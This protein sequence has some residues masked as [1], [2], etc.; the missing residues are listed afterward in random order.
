MPAHPD[1]YAYPKTILHHPVDATELSSL[2]ASKRLEETLFHSVRE[3]DLP[4]LEFCCDSQSC[5]RPT[6]L[7][8]V[9]HVAEPLPSPPE[10]PQA[11]RLC[12]LLAGRA[13]GV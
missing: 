2:L 4:C 13:R 10:L 3:K 12:L 6:G 9:F 1:P 5:G 8:H 7:R 11:G